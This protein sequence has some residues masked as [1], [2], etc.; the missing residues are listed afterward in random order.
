M[1]YLL[2][3]WLQDLNNIAHSDLQEPTSSDQ[4][5]SVKSTNKEKQ[6]PEKISN[7][8][9]SEDSPSDCKLVQLQASVMT[10]DNK[11][12]Y[13]HT[14][15]RSN[16]CKCDKCMVRCT[17]R[18]TNLVSCWHTTCRLP[19]LLT[20]FETHSSVLIGI[21]IYSISMRQRFQWQNCSNK[22]QM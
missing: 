13:W 4:S 10:V 7:G 19:N 21:Y 12:S 20:I 11:A 1:F 3:S 9:K 14:G 15:W 22:R 18:L 2:I 16:L 8:V 5:E 6:V 17:T